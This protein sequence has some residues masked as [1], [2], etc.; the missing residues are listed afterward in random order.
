MNVPNL[1]DPP[2]RDAEE[3]HSGE[4]D[5]TTGRR[6]LALRTSVRAR[7]SPTGGD[8]VSL[9]YQRLHF[10]RHV[11]EGLSESLCHRLLTLWPWRRLTGTQVMTHI[12]RRDQVVS[13]SE[14][15]S[16]PEFLV[17]APDDLL[18]YLDHNRPSQ[19]VLTPSAQRLNGSTAVIRRMLSPRRLPRHVAQLLVPCRDTWGGR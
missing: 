3:V 13:G 14:V 5:L 1:S 6:D 2:V 9:G 7:D 12:V 16:V 15:P 8:H 4:T 19:P 17:E 18:V 10:Q 11:G